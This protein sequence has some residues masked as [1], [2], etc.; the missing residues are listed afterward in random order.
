MELAWA[1]TSSSCRKKWSPGG[2][3]FDG[4]AHHA[5]EMLIDFLNL[6]FQFL[7]E[8]L[9]LPGGGSCTLRNARGNQKENAD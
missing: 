6:R 4:D 3:V 5:V 8:D 1:N 2:E 7:P 9:L